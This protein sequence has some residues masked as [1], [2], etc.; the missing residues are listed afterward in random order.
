MLRQRRKTQAPA[1]PLP[2][3]RADPA[4]SLYLLFRHAGSA[5]PA[6]PPRRP[7]I[8]L[9]LLTKT[10]PTDGLFA[11]HEIF[12]VRRLKCGDRRVRTLLYEAANGRR[13]ADH[14]IMLELMRAPVRARPGGR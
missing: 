4:S 13:S 5:N 7:F 14:G 3:A 6:T 8:G 2:R 12:S 11:L 10:S 1:N 9:G